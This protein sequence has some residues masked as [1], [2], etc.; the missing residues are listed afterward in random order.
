MDLNLT[1]DP[2][3]SIMNVPVTIFDDDLLEQ[4]ELFSAHLSLQHQL[5]E[6]TLQPEIAQVT[7]LDND[8]E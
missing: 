3:T 1:F 7:F 2:S 8:G 4:N 5:D 6:V